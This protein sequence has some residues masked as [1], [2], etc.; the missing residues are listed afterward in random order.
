LP[1]ITSQ[2]SGDDVVVSYFD[3]LARAPVISL[4]NSMLVEF[5]LLNHDIKKES[6]MEHLRS[7]YNN[8]HRMGRPYTRGK[9]NSGGAHKHA[10]TIC[11]AKELAASQLVFQRQAESAR[12]DIDV[13][14][15]SAMR[16]M[17]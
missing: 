9:Y 1:A 3:A 11:R 14:E 7:R 13:Q 4:D 2:E 5:P 15:G 8:D 17:L 10:V 12:I 16:E 6:K